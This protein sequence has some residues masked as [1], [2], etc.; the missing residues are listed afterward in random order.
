MQP[1]HSMKGFDMNEQRGLQGLQFLNAIRM[2]F[3]PQLPDKISI[4]ETVISDEFAKELRHCR[5]VN[6]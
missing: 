3:N 5:S 4:L 6:G 1:L 2:G